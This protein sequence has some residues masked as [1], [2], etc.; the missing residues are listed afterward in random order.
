MLV[1]AVLPGCAESPQNVVIS[2]VHSAFVEIF[3]RSSQPVSIDGWSLQ[4]EGPAYYP[5]PSPTWGVIALGGTLKPGQY[6]L[7]EVDGANSLNPDAYGS[8]NTL[9]SFG[10]S[11]LG[12]IRAYAIMSSTQP[13]TDDFVAPSETSDL[14]GYGPNNSSDGSPFPVQSGALYW[15][16]GPLAAVRQDAG[17]FAQHNNAS[18]FVL[19]PPT[20]RTTR[21]PV[22]P[23]S[24]VPVIQTGGV[25]NAASRVA[26][27]VAPGELLAISGS[28]LALALSQVPRASQAGVQALFDGVPARVPQASSNEIYAV[29]PPTVEGKSQ[30]TLQIEVGSV[31]S[32]PVTLGVAR[33]APG[34][35]TTL[36]TGSGQA[37]A[38]NQ[39]GTPNSVD[40]PE[41]PGSVVTVY[42]TGLS[43]ASPRDNTDLAGGLSA[44]IG[45]QAATLLSVTEA[46]TQ[47]GV[48]KV[49][50]QVPGGLTG[51]QEVLLT[52]AGTSSQ[53]DVSLALDLGATAPANTLELP[54]DAVDIAYDAGTH[55]LYAAISGNS[56][57]SP[58]EIAVIDPSS[59]SILNWIAVGNNPARIALS[60]DGQYLYVVLRNYAFIDYTAPS[61]YWVDAIQ[62][63]ELMNKSIDFTLKTSDIYA[64]VALDWLIPYLFVPDIAVL[65]GQPHS[66][67]MT[68][69]EAYS[70]NQPPI[71][72]IDDM[73]RRSAVGPWATWLNASETGS[74][75]T[76]QGQRLVDATGVRQG[77]VFP[78]NVDTDVVAT[79]HAGDRLI[80]STGLVMDSTGAQLL[81]RPPVGD[82]TVL[83]WP[84]N[85]DPSFVFRPDTGLAYYMRGRTDICFAGGPAAF[86]PHTLLLVGRPA[87]CTGPVIAQRLVS[88]GPAGL[89]TT[90]GDTDGSGTVYIY[91]LSAFV[92]PPQTS[93]PPA[94]AGSNSLRRFPLPSTGMAATPAGD[95]LYLS[96]PS[97]APPI[98]NSVVSFDVASGIFGS[99]VWVGSEPA[100]MAVSNDTQ[101]LHVFLGGSHQ[102]LRLLLP[103]LSVDKSFPMTESEGTTLTDVDMVLNP[104][105]DPKS[106]AV[107]EGGTVLIYDDGVERPNVATAGSQSSTVVPGVSYPSFTPNGT[108]MYGLSDDGGNL[109]QWSIAPDGFHFVA[110][111]SQSNAVGNMGALACQSNECFTGSG[112]ILSTSTLLPVGQ[113]AVDAGAWG[114]P[115]MDLSHNRMFLLWNSGAD[116]KVT[117]YDATSYQVTG[118]YILSQFAEPHSVQLLGGSQLAIANS[119]ELALV[120]ISLLSGS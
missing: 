59:G 27:A 3:N 5:A 85:E 95:R 70:I 71:V 31:V 22:A 24:T 117:S 77:Q 84:T 120:P 103:D 82:P 12:H 56:T 54:L 73:V 65:P 49:R 21:S 104:L 43:L 55:R 47:V 45:G 96:I 97:S 100:A 99:P 69:W 35:F 58:N 34:V 29:V 105:P 90:S 7:I 92:P 118:Q 93:L 33:S 17:C 116:L 13:L 86:D 1:G 6:Y 32:E 67:A 53:V 36:G 51:R 60:D 16:F 75:W 64:G 23:C 74:L 80:S 26:G 18:D 9:M 37:L 88:V 10:M 78:Q 11:G 91:P 57:S 15:N 76:D 19:A 44:T 110:Y 2:Q 66:L 14:F 62:R 20:P 63:I 106:I 98:G 115:L 52:A 46:P 40:Q 72:V 28:N 30:T 114:T 50:L 61:G 102:T 42:A 8:F 108:T 111:G 107:V 68:A 101:Y 25:V 89:A 112:T 83:N 39:D 48:E 4:C 113:A 79:M 94:Q 87:N 109:S 41:T 38:A 81:G 119:N